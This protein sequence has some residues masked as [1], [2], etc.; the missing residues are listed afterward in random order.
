MTKLLQVLL[1]LPLLLSA[2]TT[3]TIVYLGNPDASDND[4]DT[5]AD[6]STDSG[7]PDVHFLADGALAEGCLTLAA[8]PQV[9]VFPDSDSGSS[10]LNITSITTSITGLCIRERSLDFEVRVDYR[11][12]IHPLIPLHVTFTFSLHNFVT[13]QECTALFVHG[14]PY[15]PPADSVCAHGSYILE[16][17]TID[18]RMEHYY[19]FHTIVSTTE[20][21]AGTQLITVTIPTIIGATTV[22]P[23]FE[24]L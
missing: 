17:F 8:D 21:P 9:R 1:V 12:I 5:D 14:V 22:E 23:S 3:T 2:C 11:E 7:M 4:A 18:E 13:Q 16:Y 6:V 19:P 20:T 10:E 15:E 24:L